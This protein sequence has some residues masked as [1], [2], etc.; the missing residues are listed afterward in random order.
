M[1]I[2]ENHPEHGFFKWGR[3]QCL[4]H[5]SLFTS[6]CV[7]KFG[8]YCKIKQAFFV[9]TALRDIWKSPLA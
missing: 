9:H 7:N 5:S 8:V 1:A 4:N 3:M 6:Q 2:L